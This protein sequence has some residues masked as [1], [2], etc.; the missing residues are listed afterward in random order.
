M[1]ERNYLWNTGHE[2][3]FDARRLDQSF[4]LAM[5]SWL[6]QLILYE[7]FK[8]FAD[9][10]NLTSVIRGVV[11]IVWMVAVGVHVLCCCVVPEGPYVDHIIIW[12]CS[13]DSYMCN[14]GYI[15]VWSIGG[16]RVCN[17]CT[18]ECYFVYGADSAEEVSRWRT[19]DSQQRCGGIPETSIVRCS[20]HGCTAEWLRTRC[21]TGSWVWR[22]TFV[23]P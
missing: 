13:F 2:F 18:Y 19:I 11:C 23:E 3:C 21:V 17:V 14:V 20:F 5:G 16:Y 22:G 6:L 15:Y 1:F 7:L 4:L 8:E 10:R 12:G 9:V